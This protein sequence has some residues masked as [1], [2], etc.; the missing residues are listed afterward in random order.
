MDIVRRNLF[1]LLRSGA[2]NEFES[3]EPMSAFKWNK[4]LRMAEAQDLSYFV[5]KGIKNHQYDH[6]MNLP[7]DRYP[8]LYPD[9]AQSMRVEIHPALSNPLLNRRLKKI[10]QTEIHSIDTSIDT[11]HLLD[12]IIENVRLMLNQGIS[13]RGIMALGTFLR[14]RGD[15]VDFIKLEHWLG[16]L[17]VQRMAQLQGSILIAV[18]KFEQDEI[19][20]VTKFETEAREM[21]LRAVNH[22]ILDT[23]KEW[24]FRQGRS[25]FV[26]NNSAVMRRSIRRSARYIRFAPIE[27]TSH[28]VFSFVRSLS[29]IEE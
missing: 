15:K 17:H 11:L 14:N 26:K 13:M 20:F 3:L 25:G 2:M 10:H 27:T 6:Q 7:T 29:E 9:E 1:R 5:A 8:H 18:F 28:F 16:R 23:T 4:L 22:A 19:P 12:I 24:H 21:T